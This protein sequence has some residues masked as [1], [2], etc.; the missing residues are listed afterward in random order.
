[1]NLSN[2]DRWI[3]K[4]FQNLGHHDSIEAFIAKTDGRSKIER[5]ARNTRPARDLES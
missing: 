2:D 1:M 4:V 3:R 5:G